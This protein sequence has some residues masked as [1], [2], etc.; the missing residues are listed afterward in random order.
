MNSEQDKF[1]E[2]RAQQTNGI[3]CGLTTEDVIARLKEWDQKYGLDVL[4]ADPA[5][6]VIQLHQLPDDL[7][8]FAQEVYQFCPDT[9]DQGFGVFE[10]MY[11]EADPEELPQ[12]VAELIT[13]VN[14]ED[15]NY[16]LEIMKRSIKRDRKVG[17]WWD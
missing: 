12:G 11:G 7:D 2:L 10:E 5:T 17:L 16:G 14:F 3:N 1:A 13:G 8:A 4:E 6:V 15:E 9:V